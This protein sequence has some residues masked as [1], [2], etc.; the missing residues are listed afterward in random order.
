MAEPAPVVL[1]YRAA[2]GIRQQNR[3]AVLGPG[4]TDAR[5]EYELELT[6]LAPPPAA[7]GADNYGEQNT[8]CVFSVETWMSITQARHI[9][10]H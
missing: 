4:R 3:D 10:V 6:A 7:G 8:L 5:R 9:S 1:D 2:V